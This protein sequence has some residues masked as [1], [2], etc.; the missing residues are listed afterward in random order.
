M[1]SNG[2]GA[3]T[4][5]CSRWWPGSGAALIAAA[6]LEACVAFAPPG[7]AAGRHPGPARAVQAATRDDGGARAAPAG[8]A[9]EKQGHAVR[10]RALPTWLTPVERLLGPGEWRV[11]PDENETG[12]LEAAAVL[13]RNE[14]CLLA[15]R[16]RG[17]GF[18][19]RRL[20]LEAMPTLPR[21]AVRA[22]RTEEVSHAR[23]SFT[24]CALGA[25]RP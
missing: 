12:T 7:G 4:R 2:R 15:A 5:C 11:R 16:I 20:E 10:V 1:Q 24:L 18:G 13:T 23:P 6:A 17:L 3:R 9:G 22:A 8:R 14:A 21:N 25:T 19:G